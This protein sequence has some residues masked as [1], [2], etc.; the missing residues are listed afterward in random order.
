MIAKNGQSIG[1]LFAL[2]ILLGL[3]PASWAA[4][5]LRGFP[6]RLE[7]TVEVGGPVAYDIDGDGRLELLLPAGKKLHALE[8]DGNPMEGFPVQLDQGSG[9]VTPLSVGHLGGDPKKTVILFGSEDKQLRAYDGTGQLLEGFPVALDEVMAGAPALGDVNGDNQAEIVFGTRGGM[10]YVLDGSGRSL[11]GYPAKV[12]APVSTAVTVGRFRPGEPTLLFFGDERGNLHVWEAPGREKKG[13][14]YKALYTVASQPV[15][16]DIDDDGSFEVVFG[17]KDFKIYA[18]GETGKLASGF[19]VGTGYRIYSSCALADVNGDGITDVVATSGDGSVYAI[20]KGGRQLPGFPVK[21]GR[22]LRASPVIGDVDCDGRMEIAVGTDGGR[23]A[24]LRDNGKMYPGFPARMADRVDVAPLLSDLNG[25]GLVEIAAVSRDGTLAVFKTIKKG[26]FS[27]S[28]AWP[29]EGRNPDRRGTTCPNPPRYLDLVLLPDTPRTT[30]ELNLS[31]RF[32]DLDGD[33]E[34][35]TRI[36]WFCNSKP[37]PKFDGAR[38]IPAAPTR[39]RERWHYTLQAAERGRVFKSPEVQI[40]NTP[41]ASPK[42]A[43]L[44]DPPRTGDDLLVKIL[45]ESQDADG[46]KIRY[47]IIWLKDRVPVKGLHRFKVPS[48]MT[49]SGQRWT[50]VVTPGDGE[51]SGAPARAGVVVANTPPSAPKVGLE[52]A[53][54]TVTQNVRAVVE[55]PGRDPDGEKVSYR[56]RWVVDGKSLNLP[57][58]ASVLP[59]GFAP[60]HKKI[61]VEVASFDGNEVGGSTRA[62]TEVINSSAS[63]P[64]VKIVPFRPGTNDDLTVAIVKP[65]GDPDGDVL[66]YEVLWRREPEPYAGSHARS[67]RLPAKATKKGERWLAGVTPADGEDRGNP[68]TTEVTI[69]NTP[70][71]PPVV[72]AE[73]PR[74]KTTEDLVLRVLK[75]PKD[76]DGDEVTVEIVWYQGKK[77]VARGRAMWRLEAAKT[78]KGKRYRA[79]LTPSDGSATGP[80]VSQWFKVQNT[81][82]SKCAVALPYKPRTGNDLQVRLTE[83]PADPDGDP[84]EMRYRWY[85]N[86]KPEEPGQR[87]E[88]MEGKRVVRGQRWTV[89]ATPYDG[90]TTGPSCEASAV[91]VNSSPTAPRIALQP[92]EPG[93]RSGLS[94]KI[95]KKSEDADGDRV[96]LSYSWTI[97]GR[98]FPAGPA[99]ASIPAGVLKQGQK[100]KVTVVASD[101]KLESRPV[102][103]EV[104][105]VNSP[106]QFPRVEI[107][108]TVPL[109]SDDLNCRLVEPTFDVDGDEL[110][111]DFEW[112]LVKGNKSGPK[113]KAQAEG[114]VL[115]AKR[116]RKGQNWVCRARAHDGKVSGDY[117]EARTQVA[118]AAPSSPQAEIRPSDPSNDEKLLCVIVSD[119]QDPDGDKIKYRFVWTKD[120]VAQPFA[121]VTDRVPARLTKEKDIWQCT[122]VATDGRL[123]SPPAYSQEII[124]RAK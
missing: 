38:K 76:P 9:I 55:R 43:I 97:D 2:V 91:V 72:E 51:A 22:R 100:W 30:D 19:P 63:A 99:A 45:E 29:A 93:T 117:A 4:G 33:A 8:V 56:Y 3:A 107:R 101:G 94:C 31:Y 114:P 18:V 15:L 42:V 17:S 5:A 44:P 84:I 34:P 26:K 67:L 59:A 109:S 41:P 104:T 24:L 68:A 10:V 69:G 77:P 14:P 79:A 39:K 120:G 112:F 78:R 71:G 49:A 85:L 95:I 124:V 40:G 83:K 28:L 16:G 98:V 103:A 80:S 74:P 116:T 36:R 23:L 92:R 88:K 122:V 64:T 32:F 11:P 115:P 37:V 86:G 119:A 81:S 96:S 21:V 65:A 111:H 25:D 110:K 123:S 89:V 61:A 87:P 7:G 75:F 6:V 1:C 90:E 70:P 53:R 13:F 121:E 52:P 48:R 50:V 57:S 58:D 66:R 27:P 73:N 54:P 102:F 106:P 118:N 108:P 12:S 105:V 113:G 20:S 46:D 82:P 60:K 47:T 35:R 62:T